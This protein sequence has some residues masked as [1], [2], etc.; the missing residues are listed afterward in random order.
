MLHCRVDFPNVYSDSIT[1]LLLY[2][3]SDILAKR[4]GHGTRVSV[5][6]SIS[7]LSFLDLVCGVEELFG[8]LDGVATNVDPSAVVERLALALRDIESRR[9]AHG[10]DAVGNAAVGNDN[11]AEDIAS[12]EPAWSATP[13]VVFPSLHWSFFFGGS[14]AARAAASGAGPSGLQGAIDVDAG[15]V[16]PE[17]PMDVDAS[18]AGIVLADVDGADHAGAQQADHVV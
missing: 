3:N 1:Q 8:A 7:R 12:V 4:N 13:R 5:P 10:G 16:M 11:Q 9:V 6:I 17:L 18:A 15:G 2:F 14:T